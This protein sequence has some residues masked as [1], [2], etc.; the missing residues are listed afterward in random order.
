MALF[1][2]PAAALEVCPMSACAYGC[3]CSLAE[4]LLSGESEITLAPGTHQVDAP[5][6][7]D[8]EVHISGPNSLT[9]TVAGEQT[10]PPPLAFAAVLKGSL[11][12]SLWFEEGSDGSS[13]SDVQIGTNFFDR[14]DLVIEADR[15]NIERIS[16][17]TLSQ[18]SPLRILGASGVTLRDLRVEGAV[19]SSEQPVI[20][21]RS[22]TLTIDSGAFFFAEVQRPLI[23]VLE[24]A[25]SLRNSSLVAEEFPYSVIDLSEPFLSA[26]DSDLVLETLAFSSSSAAPPFGSLVS[27]SGGSLEISGLSLSL[28]GDAPEVLP[29]PSIEAE[30]LDQLYIHDLTLSSAMRSVSVEDVDEV[31]VERAIFDD[32]LESDVSSMTFASAPEVTITESWFCGSNSKS[33]GGAITFLSSCDGGEGCS[34]DKSVFVDA[35]SFDDGGAVSIDAGQ[36]SIERSTLRD[37]QSRKQGQAMFAGED[38]EITLY[39]TLL[40]HQS[41]DPAISGEGEVFL[42]EVGAGSSVRTGGVDQVD[43]MEGVYPVWHEDS[44]NFCASPVMLADNRENDWFAEHRVGRFVPCWEDSDGDGFG[45]IQIPDGPEDCEASGYVS[46]GGDC[47]PADPS[48]TGGSCDPDH[49]DQD[50]DGTFSQDDCDDQDPE[51]AKCSLRWAGGCHTSGVAADP[52]GAAWLSALLLL[53]RRAGA[54]PPRADRVRARGDGGIRASASPHG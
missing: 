9:A 29:V 37:S 53:R 36:L 33:G 25:L 15:V 34:V 35:F 40:A 42:S 21:V 47:S 2:A 12:G 38:A 24:S 23:R 13:L 52:L 43:V 4:A 50:G 22:S 46:I 5:L 16:M 31:I 19:W 54:C 6:H 49:I 48:V 14:L 11:S 8:H 28:S 32:A 39:R 18:L 17:Q 27:A 7:I 10:G 1:V 26:T 51:I 30:G 3:V 20:L 41:L 45:D 44:D